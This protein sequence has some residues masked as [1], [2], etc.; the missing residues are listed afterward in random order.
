MVVNGRVGNV[1]DV[2]N[3]GIGLDELARLGGDGITIPEAAAYAP[4][5]FREGTAYV[6]ECLDAFDYTLVS[7]E[8]PDEADHRRFRLNAELPT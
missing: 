8:T 7:S 3:A 6:I 5:D 4:P 2:D 1:A